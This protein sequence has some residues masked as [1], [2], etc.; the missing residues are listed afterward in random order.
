MK[1][2]LTIASLALCAL[3]LADE[4][5]A[6]IKTE[7]VSFAPGG[8]I[9]FNKSFGD[10]FVEGWDRPEVKIKVVKWIPRQEA[11]QIMTPPAS[12]KAPES[13][14]GLMDGLRIATEHPSAGE[15]VIST[16]I[17]SDSFWRH[18]LGEKGPVSVRCEIHAP[19]DSHLVI[20]HKGGQVQIQNVTG[21]IE[22]TDRDGDIVLMLLG[23]G[24]YAID[25]KS[26]MGTVTSDFA[27]TP[28][29]RVPFGESFAGAGNSPRRVRLRVGWGGITIK[30]IERVDLP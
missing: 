22:A 3:A 30:E 20:H 23:P 13:A 14:A 27:G 8:T 26:R 19:A 10:L 25:A 9:R 29:F 1:K 21:G 6:V 17:P 28:H 15:L 18:P 24:P 7:Q 12:Y 2:K 5:G 11:A 4:P 16:S